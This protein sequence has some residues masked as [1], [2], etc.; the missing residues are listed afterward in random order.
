MKEIITSEFILDTCMTVLYFRIA[1]AM[2]CDS[3]VE[4][5]LCKAND[6]AFMEDSVV[7]SDGVLISCYDSVLHD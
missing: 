4:I 2:H 1:Y 5:S 3:T 7:F 6:L